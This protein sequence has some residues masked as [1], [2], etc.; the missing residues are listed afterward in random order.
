LFSFISFFTTSS[1][2]CFSKFFIIFL[3][4]FSYIAGTKAAKVVLY[5]FKFS[6]ICLIPWQNALSA[7]MYNEYNI[8]TVHSKTWCSGKNDNILSFE[9]TSNIEAKSITLDTIFLCDKAT[10]FDFDVVPEVNNIILISS[11]FIFASIKLL[12]PFSTNSFPCS[13]N[14]FCE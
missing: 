1:L 9:F 5:S 14:S 13:I 6:N 7:P 3:Y 2:P 12:S 10:T 11:G 8:P 4:I